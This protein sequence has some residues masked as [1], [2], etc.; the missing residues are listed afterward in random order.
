MERGEPSSSADAAEAREAKIAANA[1]NAIDGHGERRDARRG[2]IA[3]GGACAR[4]IL[5][6]GDACPRSTRTSTARA[7]D[8]P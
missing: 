5:L 1:T 6:Q 4:P 2:R 8:A 7:R 3:A